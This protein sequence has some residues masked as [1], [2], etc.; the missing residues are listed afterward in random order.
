M[1]ALRLLLLFLCLPWVAQAQKPS[2]FFD[3]EKGHFN[4]NQPLPAETYF[5]LNSRV[6]QQVAGLAF[7]IHREKPAHD[8]EPLYEAL[9][10]R[11]ASDSGQV[12]SLPVNYRLR[13]GSEY[14]LELLY[15]RRVSAA[16]LQALRQSLRQTLEQYLT[17][18]LKPKSSS[19]RLAQSPQQAFDD[20]NDLMQRALRLYR[21]TAEHEAPKFSDIAKSRVK[22]AYQYKFH[23]KRA[24]EQVET[25]VADIATLLLAEADYFLQS[26]L[27]VV[28][29][30]KWVDNYP[31]A[32]VMN[33]LTL[34]V[35]YGAV[36]FE[37]EID[38]LSY[39]TGVQAGLVLPL[40]R[41]AFASPFWSRSSVVAGF[42][43]QNFEHDGATVS[44]P[45]FKRPLYA[46]LGYS[47]FRFARL[48]AGA[49]VLERQPTAAL[50]DTRVYV[51]P[52]ISLTADIRLWFDLAR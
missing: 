20:L 15:F 43:L 11:P 36:H 33:I 46:G 5:T 49:T 22:Q 12:L 14:D 45:I 37:G 27:M 19:D 40:G 47:I 10:K 1:N 28:A 25:A 24:D 17:Q 6:T 30:K 9:W 48:N 7:R 50:P 41:K 21:S 35:G 51:R 26:G 44:G 8:G 38:K 29:D 3:Y 42:F 32:K 13:G 31:V 18:T 34:Q 4:E 39:G 2:V 52:F 23:K 16:E